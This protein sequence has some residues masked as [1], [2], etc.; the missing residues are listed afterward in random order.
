VEAVDGSGLRKLVPFVH[1]LVRH[2]FPFSC[3]NM[4]ITAYDYVFPPCVV[5]D[6]VG[7]I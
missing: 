3:N 7:L 1:I 2:E 6:L 4:V 5:I